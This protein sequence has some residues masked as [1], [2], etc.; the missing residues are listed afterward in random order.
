M[1]TE[2]CTVISYR[3]LRCAYRKLHCCLGLTALKSANHAQLINIF[4]YT[5]ILV[6]SSGLFERGGGL[7]DYLLYEKV[8]V[9][10]MIYY[11]H[12]T[13]HLYPA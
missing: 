1:I 10:V 13:T 6:R 4:I 11:K 7:I 12:E 5:N 9:L 3:K 2:H 8:N